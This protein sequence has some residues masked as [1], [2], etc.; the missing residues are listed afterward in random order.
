MSLD[1][2]RESALRLAQHHGAQ[3]VTVERGAVALYESISSDPATLTAGV[4]SALDTSLT[5]ISAANLDGRLEAGTVIDIAGHALSYVVQ[6]RAEPAAGLITVSILPGL[7]FDTNGEAITLSPKTI[8]FT[9][10]PI[11][12]LNVNLPA[13]WL[14]AAEDEIWALV[15]G[16][17]TTGNEPREGDR[18][19]STPTGRVSKVGGRSGVEYIVLVSPYD[20]LEA[21]A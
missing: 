5:M 9:G 11:E 16:D 8:T 3:T 6:S 4:A 15:P 19:V 17:T 1:R 2:F 14:L 10:G 12:L 7:E 18:I 21:V 20:K 13:G